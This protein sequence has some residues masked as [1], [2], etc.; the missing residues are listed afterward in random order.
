MR[1][2]WKHRARN[3]DMASDLVVTSDVGAGPTRV[4]VARLFRGGD[5]HDRHGEFCDEFLGENR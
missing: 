5:L 4:F 3:A 1:C 2:V